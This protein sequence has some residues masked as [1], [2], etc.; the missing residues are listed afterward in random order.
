MKT[1]KDHM[2]VLKCSKYT[3]TD[4]GCIPTG[5][6][7][8]V[9]ETPFDFMTGKAIKKCI[10]EEFPGYDHNYVIDK[11]SVSMR[12]DKLVKSS[13]HLFL[14]RMHARLVCHGVLSISV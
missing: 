14:S 3:P 2:V 6:L 9:E 13:T 8:P 12:R 7:A 11:A 1:C 10:T 5:E 4:E